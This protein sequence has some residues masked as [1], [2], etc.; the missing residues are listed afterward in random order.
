MN[1]KPL[2]DSATARARA[3]ML[4]RAR[5]YFRSE[6]VLEVCTPAM[7]G[8]APT[9]PSITSFEVMSGRHR[10]YLHTSPE[11]GMKRLL[12]AGYPDIFQICRVFRDGE[13]GRLHLPEFTMIEWYRAG[14]DLQEIMNDAVT[15]TNT[16]LGKRAL[17][18]TRF[19][20]YRQAFIDS[21]DIDPLAADAG[22]LG[23]ALNADKD[24][25]QSMGDDAD[26]WLDLA[27][28]THVAAGFPVDQL[29]VIF[30]YPAS[31]AALARLSPDDANVAD[32]FEIF[33]GSI[34]IANGFVEL[35][36]A[37]V[38]LERFKSD[39]RRRQR[40]GL[41]VHQIDMNLVAALRDGMPACAGVALG[42][43][44]VLMIDEAQDDIRK[45]VTFWPGETDGS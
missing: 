29:S 33:F 8:S 37:E 19:F 3:Q 2:A 43:D 9:D 20:S 34:E 11:Y 24:L 6:D 13:A 27:M 16:L 41:P 35:V 25:R 22:M 42:L 12:A 21:L 10:T 7:Q 17:S 32:R 44:R 5:D 18:D 28:A 40:A 45:V 23:D 31:Q 15:L 30:H 36:D 4:D 38:Q 14:F 1:W 26:A 39:N